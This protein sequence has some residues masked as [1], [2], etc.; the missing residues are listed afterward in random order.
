MYV[1][2]TFRY[3]ENGNGTVHI[4]VCLCVCRYSRHTRA[5]A[6]PVLLFVQMGVRGFKQTIENAS[7]SFALPSALVTQSFLTNVGTI[8]I[9]NV[10]RVR[11]RVGLT[12]AAVHAAPRAPAVRLDD[13]QDPQ[14]GRARDGR[15]DSVSRRRGTA[16]RCATMCCCCQ[17]CACN[18]RA[19][20]IVPTVRTEWK[21]VGI[22]VSGLEVDSL[23][24]TNQ[25]TKFFKGV[26]A[27]TRAGRFEIRP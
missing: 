17:R 13:R 12:V 16:A 24:L 8:R 19:G 22:N 20:H 1:K 25:T 15:H 11:V 14:G 5:H 4:Q 10:A 21:A 18:P 9:D 27:H 7:V 3:E 26:R 2:P 23:S 6:R